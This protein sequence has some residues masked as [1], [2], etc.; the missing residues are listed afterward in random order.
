MLFLPALLPT[1]PLECLCKIYRMAFSEKVA[2]MWDVTLRFRGKFWSQ[3]KREREVT[4]YHG[5][6][7]LQG[8]DAFSV[9][10]HHQM[11]RLLCDSCPF[12]S[13]ALFIQCR[14]KTSTVLIQGD[15]LLTQDFALCLHTVLGIFTKLLAIV[16]F[17]DGKVS[18]SADS[19][20]GG[21]LL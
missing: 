6:S 20:T 2:A 17:W 21:K 4:H 18:W 19:L 13:I 16:S 7:L 11:L 9:F 1:F 5:L 8:Q 12:V 10:C 3:G 15:L 14:V